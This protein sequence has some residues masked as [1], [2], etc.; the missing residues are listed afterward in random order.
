[1]FNMTF[2]TYARSRCQFHC[3]IFFAGFDG[4][5]PGFLKLFRVSPGSA[6]CVNFFRCTQTPRGDEFR[7]V[8]ALMETIWLTTD[9]D[10]VMTREHYMS[11]FMAKKNIYTCISL[12]FSGRTFTF[13]QG[14]RVPPAPIRNGPAS[15]GKKWL[16]PCT[17]SAENGFERF[18]RKPENR[19]GSG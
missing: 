18:Y 2:P 17:G 4:R 14:T 13:A 7:G 1:M 5:K 15:V 16:K 8:D 6:G 11:V 3:P 12:E 10:Q 9:V 19:R